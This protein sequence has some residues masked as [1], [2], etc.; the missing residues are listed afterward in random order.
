MC[1]KAALSL[2]AQ[3]IKVLMTVIVGFGDIKVEC[4][5]GV[6]ELEVSVSRRLEEYGRKLVGRS[7]CSRTQLGSALAKTCEPFHI[8]S[9]HL[10]HFSSHDYYDYHSAVPEEGPHY[11]TRSRF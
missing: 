7:L 2:F 4:C 11:S 8:K 3:V 5:R 6:T 1:T 10:L 9:P